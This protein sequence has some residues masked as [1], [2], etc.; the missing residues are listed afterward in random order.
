MA[1]DS[2]DEKTGA[3]ALDD[4][5]TA[6]GTPASRRREMPMANAIIRFPR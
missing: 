6:R 2:S 4:V 5:T 3:P 1:N